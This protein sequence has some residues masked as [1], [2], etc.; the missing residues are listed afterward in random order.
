MEPLINCFKLIVSTS[1]INLM[2]WDLNL[3]G[4]K[5]PEDKLNILLSSFIEISSSKFLL[6]SCLAMKMTDIGGQ[7]SRLKKKR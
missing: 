7:C 2:I 4:S 6:F 5:E 1:H 3:P